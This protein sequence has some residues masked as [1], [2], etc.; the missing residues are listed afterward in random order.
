MVVFASYFKDDDYSEVDLDGGGF[1][2][3]QR[4]LRH[5]PAPGGAADGAARAAMTGT[6]HADGPPADSYALGVEY[7]GGGYCGW[8]RQRDAPSVQEELEDALLGK[9]ADL[10]RCEP[11][12]PAAP[13]PV[14]TPPS[15]W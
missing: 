2:G 8:Q 12:Q 10:S 7:D 1:R 11:S 6:T 4:R 3:A 5:D 15:R 9:V 13:T 14:C